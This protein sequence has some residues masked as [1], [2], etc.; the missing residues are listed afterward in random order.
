VKFIINPFIVN[1]PERV[2]KPD[3]DLYIGIS[4]WLSFEA[5]DAHIIPYLTKSFGTKVGYFRRRIVESGPILE[6][7]YGAHYDLD[8]VSPGHPAFHGQISSQLAFKEQLDLHH[9]GQ[10]SP[11]DL[12]APILKN[13]RTP[14]A[15][16]DV[17]SVL[18][19]ICADHLIYQ[20][21]SK[22]V[23]EAFEDLREASRFFVGAAHRL[24]YLRLDPAPSC[25]RSSHWYGGAREFKAR[26]TRR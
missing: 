12:V 23:L 5:N 20:E 9:P 8:E 10:P 4:G 2:S 7:V 17:F 26:D 14:S 18:T 22:E 24:D 3:L 6:H 15:Q 19:Q 13:V 16:M 21:S 1:I 11:S 25:Y